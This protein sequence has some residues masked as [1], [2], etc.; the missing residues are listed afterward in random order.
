MS[1]WREIWKESLFANSKYFFN[2]TEGEKEFNDLFKKYGS[3]EGMIHYAYGEALLSKNEFEK[4]NEEFIKAENFFPVQHWKEVAQNTIERVKKQETP[5]RFYNLNNFNEYLWFIFQKIYEFVYLDDFVRYVC[6]S[7]ISRASSEWPL[8]LI[9]FRTILELQVNELLPRSNND[10]WYNK[11]LKS[12]IDN[13][14]YSGI[15]TDSDIIKAMH[16][17][18]KNGNEATHNISRVKKISEL[19]YEELKIEIK[20]LKS[21][22]I[23]IKYLNNMKKSKL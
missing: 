10:T 18:R 23:V 16:W 12:D 6:L 13:L 14:Y 22:Y 20:K 11:E 7:A 21:F 17:I 4:A 5:E 8:S 2:R 1:K 19:N 9:D 3:D 15:I